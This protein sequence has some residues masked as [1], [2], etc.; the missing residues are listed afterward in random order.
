MPDG[1]CESH[2]EYFKKEF[3]PTEKVSL[4]SNV[5]IDKDTGLMV[6]PEEK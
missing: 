4:R 3:V 1:G 2:M 6:K 5:L